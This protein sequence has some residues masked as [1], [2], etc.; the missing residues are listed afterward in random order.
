MLL[1]LLCLVV[2]VESKDRGRS[3]FKGVAEAAV[4]VEEEVVVAAVVKVVVAV[5][6]KCH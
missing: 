4:V 6:A 5:V 3:G 2:A 1:P